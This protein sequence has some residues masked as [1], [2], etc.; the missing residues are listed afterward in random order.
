MPQDVRRIKANFTLTDGRLDVLGHRGIGLDGT[1]GANHEAERA[2]MAVIAFV[3]PVAKDRRI[4]LEINVTHG[5]VVHA[6]C[7]LR[8]GTFGWI[9]DEGTL[10]I[11]RTEQH[12]RADHGLLENFLVHGWIGVDKICFTG[13]N[14]HAVLG[15][16]LAEGLS[17]GNVDIVRVPSS[18]IGLGHAGHGHIAIPALVA[19]GEKTVPAKIRYNNWEIEMR[20]RSVRVECKAMLPILRRDFF[21]KAMHV[22][23]ICLPDRGAK[24]DE[25][26]L[27]KHL[28]SGVFQ[29]DYL[30]FRTGGSNAARDRLG[31]FLRIAG[32]RVINDKRFRRNLLLLWLVGCQLFA[33]TLIYYFIMLLLL[34]L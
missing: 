26:I 13:S 3:A 6:K 14:A 8:E 27:V 31:N 34:V 4:R 29:L 1:G 33:G 17:L 30:C 28:I 24:A 19:D 5:A 32:L 10:R 7:A 21:N 2:L 25:I 22:W 16:L 15:H 12:V 18:I 23:R 20:K 9:P 11:C